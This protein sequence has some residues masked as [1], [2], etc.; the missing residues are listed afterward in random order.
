MGPF[1]CY[2]TQMGGVDFSGKKSATKVYGSMLYCIVMLL[3]LRGGG[4]PVGVQIPVKNNY[5]T[6]EWPVLFICFR[7]NP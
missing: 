5:V 7:T 4:S 1:K 2:V 3:A 6:L